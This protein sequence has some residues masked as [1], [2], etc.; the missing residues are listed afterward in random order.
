MFMTRIEIT[1]TACGGHLG[2]VFK[3][4]GFDTP[5][6]LLSI[7]RIFRFGPHNLYSRRT[8]LREFRLAEL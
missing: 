7:L 3:G 1:C 5:S 6:A 4:E 2:H 8:T